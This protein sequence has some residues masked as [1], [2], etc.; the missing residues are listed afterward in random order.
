MDKTCED[1]R[2]KG[3]ILTEGVKLGRPY[4]SKEHKQIITPYVGDGIWMRT[5]CHC[6]SDEDWIMETYVGIVAC[7]MLTIFCIFITILMFLLL[8][9]LVDLMGESS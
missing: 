6:K 1:C 4:F 7:V 8:I 2:G 5:V 3:I 9:G